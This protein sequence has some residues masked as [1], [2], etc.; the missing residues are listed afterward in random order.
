M[1]ELEGHAGVWQHRPQLGHLA[2]SPAQRAGDPLPHCQQRDQVEQQRC[3][4]PGDDAGAKDEGLGARVEQ[5]LLELGLDRSLVRRVGMSRGAAHRLLLVKQRRHAAMEA[6]G[7]H[8]RGVDEPLGPGCGS[9]SKT[10]REP[11]QVDLTTRAVAGDDRESEVD[12]DVGVL[13]QRVNRLAIEHVAAPVFGLLPAVA[14]EVEGPPRHADDP[15]HLGNP[16]ERGDEGAADL[17]G[18]S[19]HCDGQHAAILAKC[20]HRRRQARAAAVRRSRR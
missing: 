17:P 9:A 18:R 11:V 13:D 8:R 10:L 1:D 20:R 15:I 14:G 2:E 7:G 3:F 16:L 5:R 6:V 19:C 12:D 4:W